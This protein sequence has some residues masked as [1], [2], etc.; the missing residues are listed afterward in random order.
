MR[1]G[2]VLNNGLG[3]F[4]QVG[5]SNKFQQFKYV[6]NASKSFI[7]IS[8]AN[9]NWNS[10]KQGSQIFCIWNIP[11]SNMV[12]G[13]PLSRPGEIHNWLIGQMTF[14]LA[15]IRKTLICIYNFKR[16]NFF[17]WLSESKL[18]TPFL[19]QFSNKG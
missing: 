14:I 6:M 4:S 18:Q 5:H 11:A 19:E 12:K 17:I 16:T 3:F 15:K 9:R 2:G 7:M 1:R 10:K 13:A 8:K